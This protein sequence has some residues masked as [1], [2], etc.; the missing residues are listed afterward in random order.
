[1]ANFTLGDIQKESQ[2]RYGTLEV[3][4][5]GVSYASMLR[6]GKKERKRMSELATE[7][8]NL[9]DG[10]D[11]P[12]SMDK[13]Q[14]HIRDMLSTVASDVDKHEKLIGQLDDADVLTLF[15]LWASTTQPGEV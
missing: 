5:A 3:E 10:E 6:L 8:D 9:R 2:N 14:E 15:E 12:E 4:D 7:V 13:L 1:M 11:T